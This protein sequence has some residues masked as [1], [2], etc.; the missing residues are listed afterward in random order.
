MA[1]LDAASWVQPA[2]VVA[3]LV[4]A[5]LLS[6]CASVLVPSYCVCLAD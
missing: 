3:T 1:G 6:T 4:L 2:A 5:Y